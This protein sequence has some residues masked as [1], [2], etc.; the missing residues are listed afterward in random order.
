M[1]SQIAKNNKK[2]KKALSKTAWRSLLSTNRIIEMNQ[3]QNS[4]RKTYNNSR[5][6]F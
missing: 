1:K 3:K 4:K 5:G 6:N 2:K